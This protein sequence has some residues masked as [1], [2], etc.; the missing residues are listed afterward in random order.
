MKQRADTQRIPKLRRLVPEFR[1]AS[2]ERAFLR[3]SAAT[4]R[5][6]AQ[7][8]IAWSAVGYVLAA[9]TEFRSL[10]PTAPFWVLLAMRVG[11]AVA[12]IVLWFTAKRMPGA[13]IER[14]LI[15]FALL[16]AAT[17]GYAVEVRTAEPF[18]YH[19]ISYV[20]MAAI[21][22]A[23]PVGWRTLSMLQAVLFATLAVTGRNASFDHWLISA[24]IAALIIGLGLG[25]GFALGR[26]QRIEFATRRILVDTEAR[27]VRAMAARTLLTA[28]I[29]HE[30]RTPLNAILGAAQVLRG[31]DNDPIRTREMLHV[32]EAAGDQLD[33]MIGAAIDFGRLERGGFDVHIETIDPLPLVQSTV[34]MLRQ[35]AHLAGVR[36]R[37]GSHGAP[38]VLQASPLALRQIVLNLVENAVKFG[39]RGSMVDVILQAAPD[40]AG[41]VD[42]IV[43]DD[44]PGF[45]DGDPARLLQAYQ[46]GDDV[47][48]SGSGLGL[49][50][51]QKLVDQQ[52]GRLMLENRDEG[53]ARVI[54][55]LPGEAAVETSRQREIT[56]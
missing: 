50:I 20:G 36:L 37:V 48:A 41:W 40:E 21:F 14:A 5:R 13:A 2:V 54:V 46:R 10:G 44:G 26:L 35:Q 24:I 51:V 17:F 9:L 27:A 22:C 28:Q 4:R 1:D 25:V 19:V 49:T 33:M 39:A 52:H 6:F 23:A 16:A 15:G 47:A 32:V 42:L 12:A 43:L 3:W 45:G 53:G 29:S 38:R 56:G 55:R 11:F 30:L 18:T 31:G 7:G 34:R 8:L